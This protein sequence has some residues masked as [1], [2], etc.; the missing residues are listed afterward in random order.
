VA[1]L[2]GYSKSKPGGLSFG[3]AGIA[4]NGHLLGEMLKAKAGGVPMEHVAYKGAAPAIADLLSGRIDFVYFSYASVTAQIKDGKLR[5]LAVGAPARHKAVPDIPT[6]A[7]AGYPGVELNYWFG[8]V[9][10]AGTPAPVVRKLN[11]EFVKAAKDPSML[12]RLTDMGLDVAPNTPQQFAKVIAEDGETLG[13]I[14]KSLNLKA[15]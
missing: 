3:S 13:K 10:P 5:A 1:E 7:E 14:V 4:T 2:V 11:E 9:A 8:L 12:Q 6:M 15:E